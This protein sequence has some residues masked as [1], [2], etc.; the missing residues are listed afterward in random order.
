MC[1]AYQ[2]ITIIIKSWQGKERNWAVLTALGNQLI[3][4][5]HNEQAAAGEWW[6]VLSF[7]YANASNYVL[8]PY[9][10]SLL[11][12]GAV[13]SIICGYAWL[14]DGIFLVG[15]IDCSV[16]LLCSVFWGC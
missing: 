14:F 11:K 13:L 15:G 3:M 4:F 16:L 1:L 10:Y 7:W 12:F 6:A 9:V 8:G 5:P 2:F